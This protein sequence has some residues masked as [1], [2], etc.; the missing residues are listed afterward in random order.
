MPSPVNRLLQPSIA[1][2]G[3][4]AAGD[5]HSALITVESLNTDNSF[6]NLAS[7]TAG[8]RDSNGVVTTT[9][10]S[11]VAPG[12]YEAEVALNDLGAYEV[13][14]RRDGDEPVTETAGFSVPAGAELLNAGTNDRLLKQ[15]NGGN[16]YLSD[17]AQALDSAGLPGASAEVQPLWGYLL[18]PALV[19]LL[20]S[21]AVRRLDFR[22]RRRPTS[23]A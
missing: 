16:E 3:D 5:R 21:A 17:P 8:V 13:R 18:A 15:L 4:S 23:P 20:L 22:F 9:L 7:I 2:R 14:L 6:A 12:R 1:V 10:L 19:L 11:Q